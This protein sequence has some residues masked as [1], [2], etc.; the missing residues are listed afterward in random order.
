MHTRRSLS[1]D[2]ILVWAR[3]KSFESNI[4]SGNIIILGTDGNVD[5]VAEEMDTH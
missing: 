4:L 1:I 3:H 2:G 5:D